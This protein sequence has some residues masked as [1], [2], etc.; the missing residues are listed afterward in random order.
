MFKTKSHQSMPLSTSDTYA[1]VYCD[2]MVTNNYELFSYIDGNRP[3]RATHLKNIRDSIAAKQIPVPIVVNEEY[4]ICD[5]QNR[6]EACKILK[7]PVYYILVEGLR[8]EDVQRLNANTRT[9][10]TQDFLESY[11][12]LGYEHYRR[13]R[14]YKNK[15][16]F[17]HTECMV[18][19]GGWNNEGKRIHQN[20]REGLFTV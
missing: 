5:G 3:L 18:I 13:Y 16:K 20:F 12:E 8:L 4:K 17:G 10:D 1:N 6:F 11:C 14:T 2:V 15:Y 9:W 19:L 7:K